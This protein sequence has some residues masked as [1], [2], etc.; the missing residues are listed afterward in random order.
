MYGW[1]TQIIVQLPTVKK[2]GFKYKFGFDFKDEG[3]RKVVKL[4][5]PILIST[6]VQPINNLVN[7]RLASGLENG[8]AVSAIEYSY[9]LYLIIVG[10]FSY[11]LS[12]IIFPELSKLTADNNKTEIKKILNNSTKISLLFIIP[13]SVGIALISGDIIKIIYERGEFTAH[14]TLLTSQALLYYAIGMIGYGLMEV[15]NKAFY[16]MQDSKT[17]MKISI[18]AIALNLL[19]SISL[20]KVMGYTGLPLAASITSIIIGIL[21]IIVINKKIPGIVERDDAKELIK[22]LISATVMGLLI[23]VLK[24]LII[25]NTLIKTILRVV[26]SVGAGVISY[27][28]CAILLKNQTINEYISKIKKER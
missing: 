17:P 6:W 11:T 27:F 2:K 1:A 28:A 9:N 3:I 14:S 25:G 12:N 21:M 8:E 20:V 15:L 16:A 23:I 26:I 18:V 13:M 19:L 10:V 24:N 5:I 4:A 22:I 7:L